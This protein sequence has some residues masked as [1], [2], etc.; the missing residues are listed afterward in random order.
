MSLLSIINE[1]INAFLLNEALENI[2]E[3]VDLLYNKFFKDDVDKFNQTKQIDGDMFTKE[4]SNTSILQ[5]QASLKAH[6]QNPCEIYI[7][8]GLNA[9]NP[10]K[11]YLYMSAHRDV[12]NLIRNAGSL[13]LAINELPTDKHRNF[14]NE[15]TD[16]RIK[17][18]IHHEL[19]H[20]LDDTFNNR[21]LQ[22]T[23]NRA[24]EMGR[25]KAYKGRN[26]NSTKFEIQSQM[27][28]V[29]QF[30][31]NTPEKVY[32]F[33]SFEDLVSSLPTLSHIYKILN[34][35]EKIQWKKD[36]LTRMNR[37]NLLGSNMK[38]K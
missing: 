14:K 6:E 13:E 15:I 19:L 31:N 21:H 4:M 30:K 16:K 35:D 9:Y 25:E 20:W 12:V 28:N 8:N 7:N 23:I 34:G 1:E 33:L 26:V 10:N 32:N 29:K 5:T 22:K 36:L 24:S 17:G 37:E 27:G 18:S 2:D 38:L 3:D 11:Q